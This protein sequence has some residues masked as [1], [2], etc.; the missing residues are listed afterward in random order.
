MEEIRSGKC[1]LGALVRKNQT[2]KHLVVREEGLFNTHSLDIQA[3]ES[4]TIIT[5][6]PLLKD[7]PEI[8]MDTSVLRTLCCDTDMPEM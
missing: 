1:I 2:K 4:L 5:V 3:C 8:C 7:S 6:E